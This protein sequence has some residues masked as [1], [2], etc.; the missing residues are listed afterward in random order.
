MVS[1]GFEIRI[2]ECMSETEKLLS[3]PENRRLI[4]DVV[5]ELLKEELMITSRVDKYW[6][7]DTKELVIKLLLGDI[8]IDSTTETL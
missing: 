6:G 4:K 5:R 7:T 2:G 3:E 1:R 8:V